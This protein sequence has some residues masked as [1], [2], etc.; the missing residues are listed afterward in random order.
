MQLRDWRK[1]T[2]KTLAEVALGI[3]VKSPGT[4]EKHEKG[5]LFPDVA[6]QQRYVEFTDRAVR[7]EDWAE[8]YEETRYNPPK[9]TSRIAVCGR[10]DLRADDPQ[11]RSCT[12]TNC[13]LRDQEA[14]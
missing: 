8:L 2:K 5:F 14:A 7:A 12:D 11:V 4:V 13:G 6:T 10:C 9:R 3:G 1:L